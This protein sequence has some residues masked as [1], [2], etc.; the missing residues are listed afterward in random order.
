MIHVV[1]IAE[2]QHAEKVF[3]IVSA[4]GDPA[5]AISVMAP[6]DVV[7]RL[8]EGI[9]RVI[10]TP[11]SGF[12]A[13]LAAWLS[14]WDGEGHVLVIRGDATCG[15]WRR[16]V[17]QCCRCHD[18]IGRLGVWSPLTAPSAWETVEVKPLSATMSAVAAVDSAV[19]SLAAAVAKRLRD[20]GVQGDVA[21]GDVWAAAVAAA[22]ARNLIVLRDGLVTV[23]GP[24]AGAEQPVA[25]AER[26]VAR[27]SPDER[28]QHEK[29][30]AFVSG[31]RYRPPQRIVDVQVDGGL[32]GCT[33]PFEVLERMH[34]G[35]SE[36]HVEPPDVLDVNLVPGINLTAFYLPQFHRV[37]INDHVWGSGF[38]EWTNVTRC[39]P[40]FRGH[41]QPH[42]PAD[43]GFY[44]LANADVIRRQTELAL[45]YG[46]GAFCFHYYW[47]G[48]QNVM[49]TPLRLFCELDD[50]RMKFC[51]CWANENWTRRWDGRDDAVILRQ[52]HTYEIDRSFI[53][54]ILPMLRSERYLRANGAAVIVIYRPGLMGVDIERTIER[55]RHVADSEGVGPLLILSSN[56]Q[57]GGL[58]PESAARALDGVVEFP[59]HGHF[60]EVVGLTEARFF[61]RD[62]AG[63]FHDYD[64]AVATFTGPAPTDRLVVPGVFPAWDNTARRRGQSHIYVNSSP[65]KFRAWL[66]AALRRSR[67]TPACDGMVFI[68][69]WNE[70]AEG[71]HLE[72]CRWYGHAHLAA[73]RDAIRDVLADHGP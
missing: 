22:Y 19:V 50:P 57:D 64:D 37:A 32:A 61:R 3:E 7:R 44:D 43:L 20:L 63:T 30:R 35:R 69:A 34:T 17:A 46:V 23:G 11:S 25:H 66:A 55:W 16:L 15:D 6:A 60:G 33:A 18:E 24:T 51:L 5:D 58:L 73:C 9:G 8:P 1:I 36:H 21:G 48:G 14:A 49:P 27:L 62:F 41:L 2:G 29:L 65:P 52:A 39:Q 53:A 42:L 70:W 68:N 31:R 72:P 47:F 40:F 56:F 54:D 59:P 10:V 71:D 26:I 13:A 12:G 38:T 4:I 28:K 67:A 45:H